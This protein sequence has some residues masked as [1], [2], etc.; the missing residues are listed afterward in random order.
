VWGGMRHSSNVCSVPKGLSL[1]L[2]GQK[3]SHMTY[4]DCANCAV[5][6]RSLD[7][8]AGMRVTSERERESMGPSSDVCSV[9]KGLSLCLGGQKAYPM[10]YRDCANCAVSVR[11]LDRG[12]GMRV[13]GERERE[14]MGPSRAVCSVRRGLSLCLWGHLQ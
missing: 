7:R 3:A 12:A 4:R 11:S 8:G 5:S 10:I 14:G 6:V 2:G 1:C 13:S 9:R